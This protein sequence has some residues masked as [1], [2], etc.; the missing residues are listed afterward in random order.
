MRFMI[1]ERTAYWLTGWINPP[2]ASQS[3]VL[4]LSSHQEPSPDVC[5]RRSSVTPSTPTPTPSPRCWRQMPLLRAEANMRER[6]WRLAAGEHRYLGIVLSTAPHGPGFIKE[7]DADLCAEPATLLISIMVQTTGKHLLFLLLLL[8]LVFPLS[9]A[10]D[11]KRDVRKTDSD[12]GERST[13]HDLHDHIQ[14]DFI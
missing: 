14:A 6:K 11:M 2:S 10:E 5:G 3:A 7:W 4:L 9:W 13:I 1:L 8:L 12:A